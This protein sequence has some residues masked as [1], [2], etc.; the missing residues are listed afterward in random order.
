MNR[1]LITALRRALG[2]LL[3]IFGANKFIGFLPDFEFANPAA[4]ILLKALENSYII[5]TVAGIEIGVGLL[6][7]SNR[8]VPFSLLLLAPISV[9]II[10]FHAT[11]DLANIGPGIFVFLVNAFLIYAYWEV[12]KKLF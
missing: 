10:L 5:T 2:I 3:L 1:T 4:G 7:I 12:F 6:L 9:N 8:A 11:L